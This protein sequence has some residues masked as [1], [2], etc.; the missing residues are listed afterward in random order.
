MTGRASI[1]LE[2]HNCCTTRIIGRT[3]SDKDIANTCGGSTASSTRSIGDLQGVIDRLDYLND[4]TEASLG[5]DAIWFSPTFPSPMADFGYDVSDYCDVHPDFGD[6]ATMDRLIEEAHG[7]G[8]RVILDF[9]PNHTSSEHPWFVESR[10]SRDSPKRDWYV[11]RDAKEEGSPPNNWI[12]AF[13]GCC[14]SR[15]KS[16]RR[17]RC[18]PGCA[19]SCSSKRWHG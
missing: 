5:V 18:R 13:G 8:I 7:R 6:L 16:C 15:C 1:A 10:W 14:E 11:W 19:R 3:S 12:G 17:F 2:R 9:V 4:G